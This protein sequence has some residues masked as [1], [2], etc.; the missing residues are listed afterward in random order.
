MLPPPTAVKSILLPEPNHPETRLVRKITESWFAYASFDFH[1][2]VHG[3]HPMIDA[4]RAWFVPG[5]Y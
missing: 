4:P 1:K 3:H 5:T 2:S